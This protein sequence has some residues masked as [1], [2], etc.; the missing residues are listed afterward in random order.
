MNNLKTSVSELCLEVAQHAL[1]GLR[2]QRLPERLTV[3]PRSAHARPAVGADHDQQR[4]HAGK[5]RQPAADAQTNARECSEPWMSQPHCATS[6][7]PGLLIPTGVDG[8]YGRSGLFEPWSMRS[9]PWSAGAGAIG[10]RRCCAFRRACRK[11]ALVKSGYLK[12]FPQLLGTVHCFCGNEAGHRALLRRSTPART[13]WTN[14][15]RPICC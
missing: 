6:C 3:Q 5:H 8:V 4:P 13:G 7:S 2:H 12:S 9:M 14:K 1:A 10:A 15:S 11:R